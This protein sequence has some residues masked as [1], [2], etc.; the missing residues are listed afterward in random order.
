MPTV[1]VRDEPNG[2][3]FKFAR[4]KCTRVL[5]ISRTCLEVR[6]KT[7]KN[8]RRRQISNVVLAGNS[9]NLDFPAGLLAAR[10]VVL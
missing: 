10:S 3:R 8:D 7:L 4:G 5:A 1:G 6:P 2:V 9:A